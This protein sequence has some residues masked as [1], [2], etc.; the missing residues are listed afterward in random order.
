MISE[1]LHFFLQILAL[2]Y[3]PGLCFGLGMLGLDLLS[4]LLFVQYKHLLLN[5]YA[6]QSLMLN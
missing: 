1:N 6:T 5:V 2:V 4:H 3:R